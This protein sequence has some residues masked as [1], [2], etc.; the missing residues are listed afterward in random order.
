[1]N[2]PRRYDEKEIGRLLRRA[3]ELQTAE[4]TAPN[5]GGMTLEE[6]E[7]IAVEAGIDPNYLRRA[8]LE[9]ESGASR[10]TFRERV[11]GD[12]LTLTYETS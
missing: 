10:Q 11:V 12:P 8:A 9:L 3:T 2:L 7:E 1:M 5:P 6:L 4:P